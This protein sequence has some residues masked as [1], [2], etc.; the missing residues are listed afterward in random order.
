MSTRDEA[1]AAILDQMHVSDVAKWCARNGYVICTR[2]FI[3][4]VAE[5]LDMTVT[6]DD[7]G[8]CHYERKQE[9]AG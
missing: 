5:R 4:S 1:A 7:V 8:G 2:D 6:F 3:E 9:V